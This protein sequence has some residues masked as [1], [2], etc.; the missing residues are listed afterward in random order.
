MTDQ[1]QTYRTFKN[2]FLWLYVL[3]RG[4]VGFAPDDVMFFPNIFP[5]LRLPCSL[6]IWLLCWFI[7]ST[8]FPQYFRWMKFVLG[9]WSPPGGFFWGLIKTNQKKSKN[10]LEVYGSLFDNNVLEQ[11]FPV[12]FMCRTIM[13][14][15]VQQLIDVSC[16]PDFGKHCLSVTWN[17]AVVLNEAHQ[18]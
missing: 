10:S 5:Y 16:G 8:I 9:F 14:Y 1:D 6:I 13:N 18:S 15:I 17:R 11:W 12:F 3:V 4:F 2:T 7:S